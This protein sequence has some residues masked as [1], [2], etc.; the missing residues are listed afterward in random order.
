M[1]T[2]CKGRLVKSRKEI[3]EAIGWTYETQSDDPLAWY[4]EASAFHDAAIVLHNHEGRYTRVF[5]FNAGLS[6]EL[7]LKAILVGKRIKYPKTH[8]LPKLADL[9]KIDVDDDQKYTLEMFATIIEW[10]GRYPVPVKKAKWDEFHDRI[11]ENHTVR[12]QSGNRRMTIA[13]RKRFSSLE[14]YTKLWAIC[15]KEFEEIR[16]RTPKKRSI[17]TYSRDTRFGQNLA[18]PERVVKSQKAKEESPMA[19]FNILY[20]TLEDDDGWEC[21][22]APAVHDRDE[23]LDLFNKTLANDKQLGHFT[24]DDIGHSSDY[25]LVEMVNP[26][27]TIHSIIKSR[28]APPINLGAARSQRST[29]KWRDFSIKRIIRQPHVGT[30]SKCHPSA[31]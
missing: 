12:V 31:N 7:A 10:S 30:G 2:N 19:G 3:R 14:N 6:L 15:D 24:F 26:P 5:A 27:C 8:Q 21:G 4:R 22:L 11:L 28:A 16:S 13:D 1:T 29:L 23:A 20:K 18:V 9:A 17:Y 25:S